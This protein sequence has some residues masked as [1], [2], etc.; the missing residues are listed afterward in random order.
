MVVD[1]SSVRPLPSV[2]V[3]KEMRPPVLLCALLVASYA[4]GEPIVAPR[5]RPCLGF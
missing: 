5:R 1:C 2:T 3:S 4:L